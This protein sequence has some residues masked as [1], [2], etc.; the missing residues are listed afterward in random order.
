MKIKVMPWMAGVIG[1]M[2]C[3]QG[4]YSQ[5]VSEWS[6]TTAGGEWT[7]P[8]MWDNGVPDGASY[9]AVFPVPTTS[10]AK[11]VT[12]TDADIQVNRVV[13]KSGAAGSGYWRIGSSGTGV[14]TFV[15]ENAGI[16]Y[17]GDAY[18]SDALRFDTKIAGTD[19]LIVSGSSRVLIYNN[20]NTFTGGVT[21]QGGTVILTT[22]NPLVLNN[23]AITVKSSSQWIMNFNIART[24]TNDIHL[25]ATFHMRPQ[26]EVL[27]TYAGKI[28]ESGGPRNVRFSSYSGLGNILLTGDN[29]YSGET[30]IGT[31]SAGSNMIV[32][33]GSDT[34]LGT[35]TQ[36]TLVAAGVENTLALQNNVTISGK[37]LSLNGTGSSAEGA[38]RSTVG[39][40]IWN[41]TAAIGANST[42][43]LGASENSSLTMKG[44]ISGMA[45]QDATE[46]IA[47]VGLGSVILEGNNTFT[48]GVRVLEGNLTGAHNNAL[49]GGNLI[50]E[51]AGNVSLTI[52][53]GVE[54]A[55]DDLA[56]GAD[57]EFVFELGLQSVDTLL[58]V[59]GDQSG[60]ATYTV[61]IVD[62]GGFEAGTYTLMT[63]A[64]TANAAGFIL[65]DTAGYDMTLNWSENTLTLNVI[66]EP[67]MGIL[68]GVTGLVLGLRR[69]R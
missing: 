17:E 5:T 51:A 38:L 11:N 22:Y 62:V 19:G 67:G 25:E 64:G 32:H 69:R 9:H 54:L 12:I 35:G 16:Y 55:V 14:L 2:V 68:M 4:G 21:L 63:V 57:A 37:N 36:V 10:G 3:V 53:N 24:Y 65:G 56:L 39:N 34:A 13:R 20:G 45:H 27:V 48:G 15:G 41:G 1:A 30:I 29:A 33:A 6:S 61:N 52:A 28:T 44:E 23:N 47:K 58:A 40:N 50:L 46:G 7:D 49:A 66:P 8:L 43:Y 31:T 60:S 59:A 26:Q 18:S 42:A